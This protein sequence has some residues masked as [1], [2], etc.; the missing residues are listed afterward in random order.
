VT[1]AALLG[2]PD[3]LRGHRIAAVVQADEA[4]V[5]ADALR[6]YCRQR[7]PATQVP[8]VWYFFQQWPLTSSGK[9]DFVALERWLTVIQAGTGSG[10]LPL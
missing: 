2:L 7:F 9:T 10:A 4:S 3:E 1:Q 5:A 6:Q 8:K